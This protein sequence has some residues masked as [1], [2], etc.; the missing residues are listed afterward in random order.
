MALIG[1]SLV[2]ESFAGGSLFGVRSGR[3]AP[4]A[5][6]LHGWGRDHEDFSAVLC[7]TDGKLQ[8]PGALDAIALDLP[9]FGSTPA[10][11]EPMG[12]DWYASEVAKVLEVMDDKVV[13]VG[14]SF[15][16]RVAVR[17][18]AQH[19]ERVGALVLTGAP[20]VRTALQGKRRP[21]R[22]YRLIRSL[23]KAGILS[24]DRL[25]QARKRFGS[26]DY[27]SAKGVM[28]SVLV[29]TLAEDY[30]EEISA[31]SCPVELVWG[32]MDSEVP[33]SV[34]QELLGRWPQANLTVCKGAGHLLPRSN[35]SVLREAIERH[36]P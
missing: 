9:G 10:P 6:V 32:D 31:V 5:L 18:A 3:G 35:P 29:R 12:T 4:W 28:R 8:G 34:A 7:G 14:H 20:L 24:E 15:G 27:A 26:S 13:V 33:L 21:S 2:L 25:E 16:G 11:E 36:K 23:V 30:G 17:V 19:P 1:S 22:R